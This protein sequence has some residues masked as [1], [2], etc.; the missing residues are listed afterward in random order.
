MTEVDPTELSREELT[1][2]VRKLAALVEKRAAE[3]ASLRASIEALK[4][5]GKRQAAPFSKGTRKAAP[6]KPGR[7]PGQGSFK[8]RQAPAPETLSEPPI[9]VPVG[10]R[11]PEMR[12][13]ARRGPR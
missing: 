12:R 5:S 2:L 9:E 1:A 8:T 4:R 10:G 13:R 7:K 3:I 11:V 6:K